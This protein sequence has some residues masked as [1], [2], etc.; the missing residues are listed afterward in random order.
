[1]S[2]GLELVDLHHRSGDLVAL[3]GISFAVEPGE[4]VGLVGRNGA[5]KTTTMSSIIG[6]MRPEQGTVSWQGRYANGVIH[7]GARLS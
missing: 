2:D 3:A 4:I 1:V 6:I 5:G 7:G